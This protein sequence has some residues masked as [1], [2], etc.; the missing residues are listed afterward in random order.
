MTFADLI[1]A[2]GSTRNRRGGYALVPDQPRHRVLGLPGATVRPRERLGS[3]EILIVEAPLEDGEA[4]IFV[5]AHL[6]N[7]GEQVLSRVGVVHIPLHV[8]PAIRATVIDISYQAW[9][10]REIDLR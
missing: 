4:V 7:Q 6:G 8:S 10:Q 3:M 2:L 5:V 9:R 1:S